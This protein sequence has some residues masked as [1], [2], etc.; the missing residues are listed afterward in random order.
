LPAVQ[1][2]S[3]ASSTFTQPAAHAAPAPGLKQLGKAPL[4][5]A[6]QA[7]GDTFALMHATCAV[8]I[9]SMHALVAALKGGS[10]GR[11]VVVVVGRGTDVVVVFRGFN[12]VV[13][14]VEWSVVLVTVG[15]GA[16]VVVVVGRSVV[17]V[18]RASVVVV[19]DRGTV[20]VVTD[21]TV[22]HFAKQAEKSVLQT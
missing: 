17:V 13:V 12:V 15:R 5:A 9:R 22:G 11:V 3:H 18:D 7:V 2:I 16:V 21:S 6:W 19:L 14:I 1:G 10:G 8:V 20:V 4:Y